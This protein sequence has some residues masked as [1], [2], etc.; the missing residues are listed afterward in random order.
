MFFK[1]A[2]HGNAEAQCSVAIC[3]SKGEGVKK[4]EKKAFIWFSKSAEQGNAEA[5]YNLGC[6]YEY[7]LGIEINKKN[8]YTWYLQSA[9]QGHV[10]AKKRFDY[11]LIKMQ[12]DS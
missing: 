10:E 1:S 4:N 11:L 12:N 2:E 6:C 7:G 9:T 8:A 5:Q 3:Y